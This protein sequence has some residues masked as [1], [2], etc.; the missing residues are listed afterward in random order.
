MLSAG[1]AALLALSGCGGGEKQQDEKEP[2][3]NFTVDV[4]ATFP[5]KQAIAQREKLKISVRNTD[6]KAI[7][8]VAI[9]VD[10]FAKPSKRSDLA[11]RDRPVWIL[12]DGPK[13]GDTAYTNTWALGRL[14]PGASRTFTWR[15]T[16]IQ[17]GRHTIKY[18]VAAG[19]NGKAKAQL[20][21]GQVPEGS[22]TVD[23]SRKPSPSTVDPET[24]EVV[25]T[26]A[27]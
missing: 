3:G 15:V 23:V 21:G 25:R 26:P 8:N 14:K 4:D 17:P 11:D 5:S 10:S 16:A 6:S 13:G 9:T 12:E 2:E 7:P 18:R 27:Q 19:L 22:F 1:A 24:G 20:D